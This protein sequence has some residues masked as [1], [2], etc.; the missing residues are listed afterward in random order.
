MSPQGR[1]TFTGK[2]AVSLP[3]RT[4]PPSARLE[5]IRFVRFT[6]AAVTPGVPRFELRSLTEKVKKNK[7]E[8]RNRESQITFSRLGMSYPE[9]RHYPTGLSPQYIMQPAR[10]AVIDHVI[11]RRFELAGGLGTPGCN[12]LY[13]LYGLYIYTE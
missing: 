6:A 12:F 9:Q 8:K 4:L 2:L 1:S 13:D 10:A 5:K 3:P 7:K 11:R